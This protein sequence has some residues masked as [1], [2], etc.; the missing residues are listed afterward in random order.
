MFVMLCA[1]TAAAQSSLESRLSALDPIINDAIA[2]QQVPGAVLIVGH[3]GQV[4][5]RK[6]YGNRALEPRRETMTLDTIFDCAS[7]T[8]V[9]STTTAVMQL[10]EQGKFRMSDPVAKYLPEFAQNGKQDITIRQ[11]LVHYSGL[12][13]DL[14]LSKPWEGKETAYRMAFEEA[15]DRPPGSMLIYSDIN[16]IVLGALVEQLSGEPLDQYVARHVFGPMGMKETRYLP[17]ASWLPRIAPTEEDENHRM[18]RGVVHDPSARR[19][20]GVAGHA[21][22]F[23][24]GDDLAKFAQAILD[25]GQGVLTPATISKMTAPQ[26]PPTATT[27]R[28]FGWDIDSPYSTNRGEL[29]PVGSFGHTGFTGTSLWIDPTTKTYVLLLT[30][31][32]HIKEKGSA[33]S[34]RTRV[35]TAVAVALESDP[36]EAEKLRMANATGYNEMLTAGRRVAVRN[37]TV[38]T[39]IDVL[40]ETDFRALHPA[41][42]G[43]SPRN[44]GLVTN[45]TGVDSQ[46]RRTIDVLAHAPGISLDAIFSPEHGVTGA[47]DTTKVGNTKDAATGIPVYSVYGGTDAARRPQID[48]LKKLDAVVIDLQNAGVRFYTY[49]TTTGY[50]LEAAAKAGIEIIVLDRPDP[51][52][53]SFVQ[54]PILDEGVETFVNYFPL[55]SRHG[56]TL[57]E[58]AKMFNSERHI[59][60]RLNVVPMEGWQRGDWY[61][62]TGL[63]WVAP[64]PNLRDLVGATLYPGVGLVEGTNV[65]VGRGT[66]TPF[67]VMGAPWVKGRELA[68]YLNARNIPSVRFVPVTFTPASS[69]YS[70]QR[71]EGVNMIVLDRNAFN[72]PELGIELASALQKLYPNDYKVATMLDILGNRAVFDA[73]VAGEDPQR[74]AQDWQETLDAFIAKREKYLI[75][76]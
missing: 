74:I 49:D 11:L 45:Q 71:C 14:D 66:E 4:V 64:S 44:I 68:A 65:S 67:E 25:G 69:N 53:G 57:G 76:K 20:G 56:M 12:G 61:D 46:G 8:K 10:W 3:D 6:A 35:G 55:P 50:F 47:L 75:Y 33:V 27:L 36:A 52:T 31:A 26:Q 24:T 62:S 51:I 16:F 23:S 22:V 43:E 73:I 2:Q 13:P 58:L 21:G 30:N 29:F 34:L 7:L 60:A 41:K 32:V 39:G 59:N 54:G 72:A 1:A 28:G 70:G 15:P 9:V 18:L 63:Q 19:M 38:K 42:T 48:V 37:G 17:P 40:E 5:F